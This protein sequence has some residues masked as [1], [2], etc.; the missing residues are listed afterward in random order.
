MI[1]L[2]FLSFFHAISTITKPF[3]SLFNRN[4]KSEIQQNQSCSAS[5]PATETVAKN[6]KKRKRRN[7][8]SIHCAPWDYRLASF[9][10]KH[11][12]FPQRSP[13]A[14]RVSLTPT[15]GQSDWCD[16]EP[17]K[18]ADTD[19]PYFNYLL[20]NTAA[21]KPGHLSTIRV[22]GESSGR[23]GPIMELEVQH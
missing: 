17:W 8:R 10:A 9:Y 12:P 2:L 21:M 22:G 11:P 19:E 23:R 4:L 7:K 14:H 6:K 16:L 5:P 18:L 3:F 13:R 20:R 1:P 15:S